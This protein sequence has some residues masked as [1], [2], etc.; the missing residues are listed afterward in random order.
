[1]DQTDPASPVSDSRIGWVTLAS[2][3]LSLA[4][5][6]VVALQL[7]EL[8]W[9]GIAALL[10]TSPLFWLAFLAFYAAGPVSDWFA[11]A[12]V[13]KIGKGAFA[14]LARKQVYNEVV[15]GYLGEAYF[16]T[17]AKRHLTGNI[18]GA[19][20]DVAILS[21]FAGNLITIMLLALLW[22]Q[23]SG[24]LMESGRSEITWSLALVLGV[25]LLL[26]LARRRVF[27]LTPAQNRAI[28]LIHLSRNVARTILAA[29]MWHL[30]VPEIE[31]V[32]WLYLAT[33]RQLVSRLPLVSNK[34]LIFAG[35]AVLLLPDQPVIAATMALTAALLVAAHLCVGLVLL[36]GD[37]R[38]L[39]ALMR[40]QNQPK[41]NA[42]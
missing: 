12:R 16:Y 10:P 21:A 35:I 13:W 38:D 39:W 11:F 27:S 22:P 7:A 20:K 24:A 31:L 19:V 30:I 18:F 32:W 3:L 4:M 15:L 36:R 37:A 34:D 26:L 33:L 40:G 2:A 41:S 17:W 9:A 14:A 23:V 29:A 5:A 6:V 1:M 28:F 25:S 8:D 42:P